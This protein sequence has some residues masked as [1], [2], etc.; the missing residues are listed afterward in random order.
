LVW[1]N[2]ARG[3]AQNLCGADDKAT[4]EPRGQQPGRSGQQAQTQRRGET[5]R[6]QRLPANTPVTVTVLGI[7]G[8]PK[9]IG[10]VLDMSGSGLRLELS[11]PLPC[12]APVKLETNDVLMLGEVVRCEPLG[13]SYS[14][15]LSLS[16][17]LA[18]LSE[19]ERLNRALLGHDA[20]VDMAIRESVRGKR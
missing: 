5:R 1:F 2:S 4:V 19:L 16:H 10:T 14:V 17:S 20:E 15:G 8:E 3:R 11:L 18:A 13:Q 7:L 12:G 6:E 9:A